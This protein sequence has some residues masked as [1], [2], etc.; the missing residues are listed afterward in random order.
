MRKILNII[1]CVLLAFSI[2]AISSGVGSA[3]SNSSSTDAW[4]TFG[5][6]LS[7][8]RYSYSTAPLINQTFW[9]AA[10]DGQIRTSV[11]VLGTTAYV[12]SFSGTVYALNAATGSTLWSFPTTDAVWSSP[13]VSDGKVFVGS[14]NGYVYALN[15]ATGQKIW[16][17]KTGGGVFSSPAVLG[18]TVYVGST[19]NNMYAL[20]V[21]T[22]AKIWNYSTGGQIR[23]SAAIVNGIIYFGAQNGNFYALDAQT[24]RKI[25]SSPTGDGDTYTNS[26]PAVNNG[27]VYIGSTDHNLYAF[28]AS[29]GTRLWAFLA[30]NKVSSSPA[31]S[32]GEVYVGSED[33]N[34]YAIAASTGSLLWKYTTG[35]PVYSS[36][37]L[38]GN[39]V[40]VGSWD[41]TIYAL[42]TATGNLAWS[43]RTGAGI[44]SAPTIAGGILFVGSYDSKVYAFGT[45]FT[46]AISTTGSPNPSIIP[47]QT[48]SPNSQASWVPSPIN[49]IAAGAVT[50]TAVGA[51]ALLEALS[52]ASLKSAGILSQL[53]TKIKELLPETVKKWFEN[54]IASKHKLQVEKK[55]WS[56]YLPT[57]SELI[58]YGISTLILTFSFAYVKV[59]NLNELLTI[60]PTFLATSILV[61]VVKNYVLTTYSRRK[62]VWTE[63][64]LWYFGIIMFLVSTLAFRVP[65]SSPS[66]KAHHS[67]NFTERLS[68][69]LE[70]AGIFIT[71]AFAGLFFTMSRTQFT[72]IGS[73]GLAMCLISAF[74][75]TFPIEPMSGKGIYKYNKAIWVTLFLGTL[76]LYAIWLAHLL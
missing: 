59:I 23:S 33:G 22:G 53:I 45:S 21:N 7:G 9:T 47:T 69:F 63:Y 54:I 40:Y 30:N 61:A 75:D 72:L 36:P 13:T 51:I 37:A 32:N 26:S 43:Y 31:V 52:T 41:G 73:T 25:W 71:L 10:L 76:A 38:S 8:D 2:V 44:F 20:D 12:G 60:L 34:F 49:G 14:N 5:H 1:L 50:V 46:P 6:D 28:R 65:F 15:A 27:A 68:G 57:K 11:T 67:E 18:N 19:D 35:G 3:Q 62:G 24:G 42:N 55:T 29:D 74:F 16:D 4:A 17:F 48:S 39:I 66:R 56:S 70:C 64:K 58:V